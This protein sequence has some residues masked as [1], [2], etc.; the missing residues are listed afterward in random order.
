MLSFANDYTIGAHPRVLERLTQTNMEPEPGYGADRFTENAKNLIR[1]TFGCED[2]DVFFF[3]GGTQANSIIISTLLRSYE[4]VIA[5]TTGHITHMEAGAIEYTGHKVFELP[6]HEGKLDAAEL[7]DYL[8]L[9]RTDGNRMHMV[10][11]GLVYISWPTELGTL[12]SKQELTELHEICRAYGLPLFIDGARLGYGLMSPASDITAQE[13][14]KLCDVFYIGGTKNGALCGEAAVFS[15]GLMPPNYATAVKQHGALL[16]KGRLLGVQ[17]EALFEDGLY[18]ELG[19]SAIEAAEAMKSVFWER[20]CRIWKSTPTNQ[21][22]LIFENGE[23]ERLRQRV[24]FGFWEKYDDTH[25]VCRFVTSW[26][27]TQEQIKALRSVL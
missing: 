22:F 18:F 10:C 13:L 25:T 15:P 26:A 8:E 4:G 27:T 11:P 5:A 12:Y 23:M 7:R 17:F 2:W 20:G 1:R 19:R 21:Q 24:S 3:T 9:Y 6:S 16:A 14:P